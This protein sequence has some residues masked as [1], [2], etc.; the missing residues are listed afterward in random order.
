MFAVGSLGS[1]GLGLSS[2]VVLFAVAR[3]GEEPQPLQFNC[4]RRR[5][6]TC[7]STGSI[8]RPAAAAA[9]MPAWATVVAFIAAVPCACVASMAASTAAVAAAVTTA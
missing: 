6:Q 2:A 4:R 9:L 8:V 1:F 5:V 3:E 7:W